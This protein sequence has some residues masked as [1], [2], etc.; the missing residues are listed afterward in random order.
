LP[1]RTIAA[2]DIRNTLS[3]A[4]STSLRGIGPADASVTLPW[5]RGSTD[6]IE[7][8]NIAEKSLCDRLHIGAVEIHF[9]A[10]AP[11]ECGRLQRRRSHLRIAI[12]PLLRL[13]VGAWKDKGLSRSP[14]PA[15]LSLAR[16]RKTRTEVGAA[17][18]VR[19]VERRDAG[20]R[21]HIRCY[22]T[23]QCKTKRSRNAQAWNIEQ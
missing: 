2:F 9:D 21:R 23:D 15:G 16:E 20:R 5:T 17:N 7:L 1:E 10:V 22:T 19:R 4:G 18:G 3:N 8:K 11:E 13:R 6:E 14:R 12:A